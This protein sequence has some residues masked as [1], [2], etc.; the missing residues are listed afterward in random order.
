MAG[1]VFRGMSDIYQR[2]PRG[3]EAW[4]PRTSGF[5][6]R[7]RRKVVAGAVR[8]AFGLILLLVALAALAVVVVRCAAEDAVHRER[9]QGWEREP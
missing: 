9:E 2:N 1:F 3:K 4:R 5:S 6:E 7:R 8:Q